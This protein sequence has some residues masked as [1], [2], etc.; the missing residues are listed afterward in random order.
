MADFENDEDLVR[1]LGGRKKGTRRNCNVAMRYYLEFTGMTPK[2]LIEE[3]LQVETG[4]LIVYV[5]DDKGNIILRT[6]KIE[7]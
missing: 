3:K 4:D 1:W 6:S 5:E 7:A 2:Q